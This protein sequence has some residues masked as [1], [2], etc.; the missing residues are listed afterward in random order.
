MTK[1]ALI[2]LIDHGRWPAVLDMRIRD[3]H[4]AEPDICDRLV[5]VT[6]SDPIVCGYRLDRTLADLAL[7]E[8]IPLDQLLDAI[9]D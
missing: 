5:Q 9:T 4:Q 8:H 2:D 3:I 6:H 1:E 7:A